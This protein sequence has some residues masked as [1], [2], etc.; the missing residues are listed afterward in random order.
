[1][2]HR[3]CA[4]LAGAALFAALAAA[5]PAAQADGSGG[6]P[7]PPP[8]TTQQQAG[9]QPVQQP[10]AAQQPQQPVEPHP[11]RVHAALA[12]GLAVVPAGVPPQVQQMIAAANH[13]ARKPYVWGGGHVR[14]RARGY[15]C[16]GAV[17][18]ILHAAGLLDH[19]MVSGQLA[20]YG[21]RGRGRWMT[22]YANAV[23]TW[24]VI[25][26]LR[27]DTGHPVP[28]GTSHWSATVRPATGFRIRHII[29][30]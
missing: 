30:L 2:A 15:D 7:G 29:G 19:P 1:M 12:D 14:W 28:R 22:I 17:S 5:A 27:F 26:G 20:H 10:T 23:H 11:T 24:I 25:A 3:A 9:Q 18:Y 4:A 6:Q 21:L 8:Q 16:S 13:I